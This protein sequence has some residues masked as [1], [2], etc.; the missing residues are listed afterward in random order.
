MNKI[1]LKEMQEIELDIMKDVHQFCE[2]NDIRYY[3]AGGTLL[4][5][6]RHKGFIPWDD[7]IDIAMPRPDYE[8]FVSKY[9]SKNKYYKISSIENNPN[10]LF[11]FAKIYDT[12]TIKIEE[13][14]VYG[15]DNI[16]GVEIDIFPVDGIPENI[17]ISN[18]YFVNFKRLYTLYS[19]ASCKFVKSKNKLKI[20]LRIAL[21]IPCKLIGTKRFIEYINNKAKK[22]DFDESEFV[23]CI[24]APFYGNRER[25][26]KA[27]Y[28]DKI[29]VE[30]EGQYF[31]GPKG[32]DEYLS[33]L[34]GDYMKLP[35]EKERVTH[36]QCKVY[37]K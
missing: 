32:Y 27:S 22:I 16:G 24:V 26:L 29:K 34:Y 11:T 28:I 30:F 1:T 17:N 3:L 21:T 23:A 31:Y 33:S 6:I 14:L 37:W 25:V 2:E 35:P 19:V 5:A 10:H 12:R 8:K 20:L 13:N 4:G 36:H 15:K 7:D 18:K 9:K